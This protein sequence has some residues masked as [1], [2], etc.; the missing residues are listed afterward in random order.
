MSYHFP[1]FPPKSNA[2]E[3]T[4]LKFSLVFTTVL[5]VLTWLLTR[6]VIHQ[7]TSIFALAGSI[8]LGILVAAL[9]ISAAVSIT[10]MF[11]ERE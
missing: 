4:L 3:H 6:V 5:G 2:G 10:L 9:F 8:A 11:W 1:N 7:S